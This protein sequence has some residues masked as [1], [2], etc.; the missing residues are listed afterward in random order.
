MSLTN[1][2]NT[3]VTNTK[4][5][6]KA[7]ANVFNSIKERNAQIQ[8]LLIIAVGEAA[9]IKGGQVTNNLDW[10]T[11]IL[12]LAEET[13]GINLV[14]MVRYVKE[15]LCVNT[16]SWNSEKSRLAKVADK[17]VKLTYNVEPLT[18]WFEHGKKETVAKAFDY[19]KRVTSAINSAMD[20]EKGGLTLN[21]VMAAVM[22]SEGVTIN[23]L[24]NAIAAAN[25]MQEAA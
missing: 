8:Q 21:E 7:T 3:N 18:T 10:L 24:M 2:D 13:K 14:K 16:V 9:S 25:P 4:Q 5:F 6:V 1:Y 22:Q 20:N 11:R 12:V 17:S 19:S 15:V 23:E